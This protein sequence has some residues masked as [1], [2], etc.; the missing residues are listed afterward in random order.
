MFFKTII[1]IIVL[2]FLNTELSASSFKLLSNKSLDIVRISKKDVLPLFL[3]K[4]KYISNVDTP[5]VIGIYSKDDNELQN[6][7]KAFFD[8]THNKYLSY[9]R[10]KLFSGIAI[11]PLI[12]KSK[13]RLIEFMK[14]NPSSVVLT[15]IEVSDKLIK[16]VEIK[17]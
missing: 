14:Q 7:I 8:M 1:T 12:L 16:T 17:D 10:K 11:P 4:T 6:V 2:I 5:L 15:K 3:G 13:T 9:W